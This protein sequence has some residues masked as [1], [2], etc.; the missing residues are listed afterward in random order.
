MIFYDMAMSASPP[1]SIVFTPRRNVYLQTRTLCTRD[2]MTRY[3][4]VA[5][6]FAHAVTFLHMTRYV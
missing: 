4:I 5:Q 1:E 2:R 6:C 3:D